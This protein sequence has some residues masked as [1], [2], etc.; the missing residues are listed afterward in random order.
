M[1]RRSFS[2]GQLAFSSLVCMR[3]SST[4][5]WYPPRIGRLPSLTLGR[6]AE[7]WLAPRVLVSAHLVSYSHGLNLF[8]FRT[9][10]QQARLPPLSL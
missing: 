3:A 7:Q 9:S 6:S 10:S 8:A 4:Q 5:F 2:V 1:A